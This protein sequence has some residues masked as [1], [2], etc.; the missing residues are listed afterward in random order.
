MLL[1]LHLLSEIHSRFYLLTA[2]NQDAGRLFVTVGQVAPSEVNKG[3]VTAFYQGVE[4]FVVPYELVRLAEK[5]VFC[6][7]D[8]YNEPDCQK[9]SPGVSAFGTS[10][11]CMCV[12]VWLC[13]PSQW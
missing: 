1:N 3:F 12:S 13:F 7:G 2:S 10:P 11:I 9:Q 4:H 6:E 5:G 8:L